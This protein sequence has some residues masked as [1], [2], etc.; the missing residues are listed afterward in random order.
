MIYCCETYVVFL[1]EGGRGGRRGEGKG[2]EGGRDGGREGGREGGDGEV[3]S[4][5]KERQEARPE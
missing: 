4:K 2:R 1:R 3:A 5:G